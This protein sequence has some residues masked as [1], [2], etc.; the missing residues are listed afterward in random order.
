MIQE[1]ALHLK[2]A[3]E[4]LLQFETLS[5]RS[6]PKSRDLQG[7]DLESNDSLYSKNEAKSIAEISAKL[8]KV[9]VDSDQDVL[10]FIVMESSETTV[11]LYFLFIKSKAL[12]TFIQG[13]YLMNI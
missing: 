5:N 1:I 9:L 3:Y 10:V 11:S 6:R 4:S 13:K 8:L 7:P 2:Y 12:K